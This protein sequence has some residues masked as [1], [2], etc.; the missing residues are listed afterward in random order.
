MDPWDW[1][2]RMNGWNNGINPWDWKDKVW[3]NKMEE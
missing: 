2:D 3:M 1:M